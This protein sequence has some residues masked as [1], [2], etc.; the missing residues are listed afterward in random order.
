VAVRR[1]RLLNAAVAC[2]GTYGY[3]QT[4]LKMLCDQAGLTERYFYESFAN[5]DDILCCAFEHSAACR[6]QGDV[7][8]AELQPFHVHQRDG[9]IVPRRV[10]HGK[11]SSPLQF[12]SDF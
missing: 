1:A 10:D 2:F 4:T 9:A 7:N 3:H 12:S 5:F 6:I 8:V 11:A